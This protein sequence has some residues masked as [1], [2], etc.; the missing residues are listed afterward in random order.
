[1]L[2]INVLPALAGDCMV[3]KFNHKDFHYML[4]IDGGMG[5]ECF[6]KLKAEIDCWNNAYGAVNLVILTHLDN[7]HIDGLIKLFSHPDYDHTKIKQI[8]FNYGLEIERFY[9]SS[10]TP[11]INNISETVNTSYRQGQELYELLKD[12]MIP[13]SVPVIAGQHVSI[14]K[15]LEIDILSPTDD[16]LRSI[17]RSRAYQL[18]RGDRSTETAYKAER[19]E[20]DIELLNNMN[21]SE[22]GIT[23]ANSSSI[24][25][26]ITY[27]GHKILMLGDAKASVVEHSL[28]SLG[29]SEE[30]PLPIDYCKISHH[31]SK[32]NTSGTLISLIDCDKFIISTNWKKGNP[33]KECLSRIIMNSRRPVKFLCNY[34]QSNEIFSDRE[35]SKYKMQFVD[36]G[37]K[38][39]TI[40]ESKS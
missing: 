35:Y 40:D 37:N 16:E 15:E 2:Q 8:L 38:E 24:A 26:L 34:K 10:S 4:I 22:N 9:E 1:M 33:T 25:C 11:K 36:I 29:A 7:D 5:K 20:Q 18:E 27:Y 14:M 31:G 12:K 28:R 19:W 23:V 39:I 32:S 13:I 30:N 17:L 21:F 3:L 6:R